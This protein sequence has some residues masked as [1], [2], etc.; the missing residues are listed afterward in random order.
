MTGSEA[1]PDPQPQAKPKGRRLFV[2]VFTPDHVRVRLTRIVGE[3]QKTHEGVRWRPPR[4]YHTT[5][6]FLGN[7]TADPQELREVLDGLDLSPV[8]A[9]IGPQV[10][11]LGRDV[12]VVPVEG[13]DELA[14]TV[15]EA[16][17]P[18][19]ERPD[20]YDFRGHVTLARLPRRRPQQRRRSGLGFVSE[21]VGTPVSAKW[22]VDELS[23]VQSTG[24]HTGTVYDELHCRSLHPG[25]WRG[26][27]ESG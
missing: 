13:L 6:A 17:A 14:A 19:A 21:W 23:L 24:D 1:A 7:V 4:S 25:G 9:R 20:V 11:M 15:R 10:D 27:H 8:V 3:F 18:F 2:G 22:T 16:T 26:R 12:I 5:L